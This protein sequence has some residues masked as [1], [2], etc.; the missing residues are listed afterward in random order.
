[1]IRFCKALG[2]VALGGAAVLASLAAGACDLKVQSAWIRTAP[3]TATTLAAYAVL[4]NTGS[5][6]LKISETTAP[7][8]GM[9]MLHETTIVNGVA[10]MRMLDALSIPP[11]GQVALSPGGKHIMLMG[12][13]SVP[14]EGDHVTLIFTDSL[15]CATSAEFSVQASA[16]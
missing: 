4:T 12:L 14:K 8:M 10:Q 6:T 2:L 5:S 15:G 7:S 9:A 3:P 1:M 13:K 11:G 16:P